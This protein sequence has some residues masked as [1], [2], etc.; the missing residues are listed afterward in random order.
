MI[1]IAERTIE[2]F[3]GNKVN[4]PEELQVLPADA[5][6]DFVML[7]AIAAQVESEAEASDMRCFRI[8]T[9][10]DGDKRVGWCRRIINEIKAA[11]EM[12]LD[13]IKQGMV[14]YKVGINGQASA[15]IMDEFDPT[16]EEVIFM[17][18][19]AVIGG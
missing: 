2:C 14:P 9:S 11:K 5:E 4:V 19:K 6:L 1:E 10:T 12:F 3:A 7:A 8:M 13:L 18:A 15:E 17:P 16:A